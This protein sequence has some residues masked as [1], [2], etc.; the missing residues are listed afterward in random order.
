MAGKKFELEV[1]DGNST[2][3][4]KLTLANEMTDVNQ[5]FT[6]SLSSGH[7]IYIRFRYS[8][9]RQDARVKFLVTDDQGRERNRYTQVCL[10]I[11]VQNGNVTK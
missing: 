9:G 2:N 6:P 7:E 3:A 4:T 10:L 5:A 8:A 11:M 1:Y